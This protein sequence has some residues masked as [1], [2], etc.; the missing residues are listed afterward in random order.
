MV[1]AII[2]VMS[3]PTVAAYSQTNSMRVASGDEVLVVRVL[4]REGVAG[5]GF[6]FREDVAAA[7]LMARWDATARAAGRPLWQLLREATPEL[8]AALES[9]VEPGAHL[10][11]TAWRGVL[12][13]ARGVPASAPRARVD[14]TLEP[15]F[16]K[17]RWIEPEPKGE[18]RHG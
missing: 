4:T 6:T 9:A 16:A 17:L 1:Q 5:Y 2:R 18:P 7:R 15:E 13:A 11:I 14:W 8:R 12:D 3:A 10:W